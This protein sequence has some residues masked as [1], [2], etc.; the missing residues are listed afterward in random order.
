[1]FFKDSSH[2]YWPNHLVDHRWWFRGNA[3]GACCHYEKGGL[4]RWAN[5]LVGMVGAVI[6]GEFFRLFRINFGLGELK[7]TFEDLS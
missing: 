4:G 3:R 1:L 5:L 6:G 2:E 7:V